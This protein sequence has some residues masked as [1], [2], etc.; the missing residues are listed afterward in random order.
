MIF[1]F[2]W[3]NV[4]FLTSKIHLHFTWTFNLN[5]STIFKCKTRLTLEQLVNGLA[6]NALA[7]YSGSLQV[8]PANCLTPTIPAFMSPLRLPVFNIKGNN[9][10]AAGTGCVWCFFCTTSRWVFSNNISF[11]T[12]A[13]QSVV[14]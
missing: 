2:T 6:D 10:P 13:R 14:A 4:G 5:L 3:A 11:S 9:S 7:V 12:A 8:L 1:I